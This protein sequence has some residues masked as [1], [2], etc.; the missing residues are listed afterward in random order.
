M[1]VLQEPA[2][3]TASLDVERGESQPLQLLALGHEQIQEL[4]AAA[5][6]FGQLL[7]LIGAGRRRFRFE[8][9]AVVGENGGIDIIGLGVLAQGAGESFGPGR[10]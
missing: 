2:D 6:Q 7:F 1:D 8:F 9:G 3:E 4:S 10:D 5:N